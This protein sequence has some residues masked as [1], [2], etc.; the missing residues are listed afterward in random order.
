MGPCNLA[1]RLSE[2]MC[3]K[4]WVEIDQVGCELSH[5]HAILLA[6]THFFQSNAIA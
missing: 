4:I 2:S 5:C 3:L 1:R 6:V